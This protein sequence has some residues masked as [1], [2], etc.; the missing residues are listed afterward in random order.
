[1]NLSKVIEQVKALKSGYEISHETLVM[2]INTVEQMILHDIVSGREGD[3][4][5]LAT[6]SGVNDESDGST[7][8]FAQPP[9]DGVYSQYC[10]TQ[11][12]LLAED[13]ERYINDSIVFKDTYNQFKRYWWQTHRQ[14][15]NYKYH[16]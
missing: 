1:M 11:I 9:Y 12:D 15:N 5:I 4:E 8:L 2:Y 16:Q 13:G 7:E 3:A 6:F 14:K 10:A